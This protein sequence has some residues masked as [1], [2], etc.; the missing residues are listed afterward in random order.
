MGVIVAR[1]LQEQYDEEMMASLNK[2]RAF[3]EREIYD[4]K[5]GRVSDGIHLD[6]R[7]QR[8]YNYT[9]LSTYYLEWYRL[10]GNV[11]YL[12][13]AANILFHFYE[14]LNG[15]RYDGS[16]CMEPVD[17]CTCLEKEGLL[18]WKQRLAGHIEKQAE[19][20]LANG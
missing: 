10:S 15:A 18:D 4:R 6:A 12:K 19:C 13:D 7:G 5:T 20:I 17:I 11:E 14:V 3:I 1:A 2:H 9:W 8:V 16:L